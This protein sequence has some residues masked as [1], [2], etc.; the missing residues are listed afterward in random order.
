MIKKSNKVNTK[1]VRNKT[2][3]ESKKVVKKKPNEASIK[4]KKRT[5]LLKRAKNVVYKRDKNTCQHCL[6]SCVGS[7]RHASHVIPVS[8]TGRL[9]LYPINM[10]VLCYHCHLNWRHKNPTEAGEW[11]AT[12][13]P[14]RLKELREL[15]S[16]IP[17]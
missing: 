13:F 2:V 9:A 16:N 17:K 3:K 5:S 12:K 14:D 4:K 6:T 10:K 7:N 1:T 15:Q 11:F 8:A